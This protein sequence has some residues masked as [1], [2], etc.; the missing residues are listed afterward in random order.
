MPAA[1]KL[2]DLVRFVFGRDHAAAHR[3][4]PDAEATAEL[5]INFTSGLAERLDAIRRDIADEVRRARESYN[6][7]E[8]GDRLE[9]I[10]RRHGIGSAAHGRR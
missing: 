9:D 1:W 6:R 10:R 8:Q 4:M 2:A 3:A 5:F 7:S